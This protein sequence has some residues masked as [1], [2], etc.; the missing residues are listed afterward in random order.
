[1]KPEERAMLINFDTF[2]CEL[3]D[4]KS[5][6]A[7]DKIKE[8]YNTLL[9]NTDNPL[10]ESIMQNAIILA[11]QG[12]VGDRKAIFNR[13]IALLSDDEQQELNEVMHIIDKNLFCYHFQPIVNAQNGEIYSYEALMRPVSEMKLSP[14]HIIK[15]AGITERLNDIERLTFTNILRLIDNE[16]IYPGKRKIFINSIPKTQLDTQNQREIMKLMLKHSDNIVVEMTEESELDDD[17]LNSIRERLRNMG[18]Q[19]ALDDY[20]TGY[21]NVS[22]LLRYTPEIV[23]IDRS[24]ITGIENDPKKR[25]FVREIVDF[26]HNN[27]IKALAEGVETSEELRTVIMMGADLIQ[28]FYTARPTPELSESIPE[29]ISAEIRSFY[30]EHE[31]GSSQQTYYADNY[32]RISL[33]KLSEN[34]IMRLILGKNGDGDV[35]VTGKPTIDI[36]IH[37]ETTNGYNGKLTLNNTWL[38][39]TK[40]RPCIIL[41]ENSCLT[42]VISGENTLD[43]GGILVPESSR[44][45]FLG[46]GKLNITMDS[47]EY[48]GIGNDLESTHGTLTFDQT[49]CINITAHGKAGVG[50]GSGLGGDINILQGQYIIELRG[51]TGLGIGTLYRECKLDIHNCDLSMELSLAKGAGLG[52]LSASSDVSIKSSSAKLYVSG[53]ELIGIGTV[54]G[55]YAKVL[56]SDANILINLRGQRCSAIAALDGSTYLHTER[57][58]LRVIA[59][60]DKVLWFGGFIKESDIDLYDTDTNVRL[61]TSVEELARATIKYSKITSGRFR[62]AINGEEVENTEES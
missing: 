1:M 10:I 36:P 15:Y 17:H 25:H 33:E 24:L 27:N 21:S 62:L 23:K 51:D 2:L 18:I 46:D 8:K 61:E 56:F 38:S 55:D 4:A 6:E 44:L 16:I 50:I 22:N 31:D 39:N 53:F 45:T 32:E 19:L 30:Q 47:K 29:E 60:G 49:G 43:N 34:N 3:L 37:I 48:F 7:V 20:G 58:G 5:T 9:L 42:I 35:T 14:F 40:D 13:Q 59:G 12:I 52:S 26:C 11:K 41:G 28:G 57:V 54:N